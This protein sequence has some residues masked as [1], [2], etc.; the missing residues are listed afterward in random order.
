MD[1]FQQKLN[2]LRTKLDGIAP[3]EKAEVSLFCF[4]LKFEMGLNHYYTIQLF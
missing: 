2:Q 4:D 1:V 3:L